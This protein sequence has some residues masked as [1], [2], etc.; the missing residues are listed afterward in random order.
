M[1]ITSA[2]KDVENKAL[3]TLLVEMDT[4]TIMGDSIAIPHKTKI[5]LPFDSAIPILEIHQRKYN[6]NM[7]GLS[8]LPCL[9]INNNKIWK[10]VRCVS[11]DV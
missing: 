3:H 10:Q 2:G 8:I 4:G 7:K 5:S 1:K 6:Q 11:T 9:S